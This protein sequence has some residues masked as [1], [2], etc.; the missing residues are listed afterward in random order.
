MRWA[1]IGCMIFLFNVKTFGQAAQLA[2]EDSIC[3][4]LQRNFTEMDMNLAAELLTFETDLAKRAYLRRV[5]E[6][7]PDLLQNIAEADYFDL[8]RS[9]AHASV[10]A[11]FLDFLNRCVQE[12]VFRFSD[13]LLDAKI[14]PILLAYA[15]LLADDGKTIQNKILSIYLQNLDRTDYQK[16]LY[17]WMILWHL[18]T[19][20]EED[21]TDLPVT[22]PAEK[23]IVLPDERLL[24]VVLNVEN[25]IIVNNKVLT[26]E[27]FKPILEEVFRQKNGVKLIAEK[28]TMDAFYREVCKFIKATHQELLDEAAAR[29]DKVYEQ[30]TQIDQYVIRQ[31]LPFILVE[32]LRN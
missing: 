9:Q 19:F 4:C 22:F 24:Q 14:T 16:T 30:L 13:E 31:E 26:F 21:T 25:Q 23:T 29:F 28:E 11:N 20:S 1:F 5:G 17:K 15:D 12:S 8:R 6:G 27:I 2:V 7:Y 3:Q 32:E 10:E 18:L